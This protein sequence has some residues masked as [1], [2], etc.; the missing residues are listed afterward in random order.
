MKNYHRF[1]A[2]LLSLATLI[3]I[4]YKAVS[5]FIG[6]TTFQS[7]ILWTGIATIGWFVISPIWL[8]KR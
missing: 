4:L 3:F 8:W 6:A 5:V 1:V 2:M 7:Y